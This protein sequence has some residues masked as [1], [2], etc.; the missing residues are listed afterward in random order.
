MR[1]SLIRLLGA[2]LALS[3]L[4]PAARLR[5]I[6]ARL[7]PLLAGHVLSCGQVQPIARPAG[8]GHCAPVSDGGSVRGPVTGTGV[9]SAT[10]TFAQDA[11][12][13]SDPLY[14][15]V[16]ATLTTARPGPVQGRPCSPQTGCPP[17]TIITS[18][19]TITQ[20]TGYLQAMLGGQRAILSFLP[21][22]VSARDVP[23]PP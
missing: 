22:P 7:S 19:V 23:P 5:P 16:S 9:I 21:P 20:V 18:T 1:R 15:T 3:L 17:A 12:H 11:A 14:G 2:A 6:A 4:F 13:A 8:A 10:G